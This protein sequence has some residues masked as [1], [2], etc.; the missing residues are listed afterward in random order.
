[1]QKFRP[2]LIL[3]GSVASGQKLYAGRCATCHR[4]GDE[5]HALGPDLT[6][7]RSNG[8]EKILTSI[9]DPNREVAPQ[10]SSY[11]IETKNGES[12]VGIIANESVTSVTL[13]QPN[14]VETVVARA[15][16]ASMQGQ[17]RSLMPE[18]LEEGLSAQDMA[19]LLEFIV[20]TP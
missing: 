1:M 4:L 20:A 18:G 14:G 13:R 11:L 7:V 19:D 3:N 8:K 6:S 16:I 17:G 15:S 2:A 12:V 10:F 9:L 5:G